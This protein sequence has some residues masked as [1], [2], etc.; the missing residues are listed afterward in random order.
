M[1]DWTCKLKIA[2]GL[3]AIDDLI[4]PY[5]PDK[6]YKGCHIQCKKTTTSV[7]VYNLERAIYGV[8]TLKEFAVV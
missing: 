3:F 1:I 7:N 2:K 8:D 5:R 6:D 4:S